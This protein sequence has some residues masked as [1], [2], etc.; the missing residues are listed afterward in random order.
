M[1]R[2]TVLFLS[3]I[4][5]VGA[6]A[7]LPRSSAYENYSD[8]GESGQ[9]AGCHGEF[10][11]A[12]QSLAENTMWDDDLHDV[13]RQR[14]LDAECAACHTGGFFPV[15]VGSSDGVEGVPPYGCSGCH[16][17]AEDGLGTGTVG[18]GAGLRQEHWRADDDHPDQDLKVCAACHDDSDPAGYTPVPESTLPPYYGST[19]LTSTPDDPCNRSPEFG[20]DYAG[21][22]LGLD[23]DGDGLYDEADSDCQAAAETDCFDGVDNDEDGMTDCA[24]PD[25]VEASGGTCDTGEAGICAAGTL[26]CSGGAEQCL[27]DTEPQAEGPAGDATCGDALD[28]DCDGATDEIDPDC[29]LAAETDCFDGTDNDD[30]AL[31]GCADADCDGATGEPCQTDQLGLCEAGTSTCVGGAA[32]CVSDSEPQV[33]GPAGSASCTDQVDND[34]DGFLDDVDPDCQVMAEAECFDG[35]DNDDDGLFDCADPDCEGVANGGCTTDQPG[36]CAVGS[37]VCTSGM[38]VCAPDLQA[39]PEGDAFVNCDDDLD[40]DC[41][42]L[43]DLDDEDCQVLGETDCFDGLDDDDDGLVDCADDDCEGVADGACDTGQPGVCA[44]GSYL[45]MSGAQ[46]CSPD[47]QPQPEGNMY[48]N[49]ADG[50]DNDCDGL[51]DLDDG[52]CDSMAADVWLTKLIAHNKVNLQVGVSKPRRVFVKARA[53]TRP[54]Q[55]TVTLTADFDDQGLSVVLEPQSLTQTVSPED[56]DRMFMF[57]PIVTCNAVGSYSVVWTAE[58]AAAE[59]RQDAGDLLFETTVVKCRPNTGSDQSSPLHEQRRTPRG[60]GRKP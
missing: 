10:R 57:R 53:D 15:L 39:E 4:A 32:Q 40:N 30:D 5:L 1:L 37:Y 35:L 28:N 60:K 54:Q 19:V 49:C 18:F 46:I 17:R 16:G 56:D 6:V 41:D 7:S 26:A 44:A 2:K 8:D 58:I 22:S 52:D 36:I 25:C 38:Q 14:M 9:C 23:N 11:V 34:C 45:C 29:Q 55:A 27:P 42:G 47:A 20:E 33:E 3:A 13:H 51:V 50:L 31:G 48:D 12:R 59:N 21:L 43:V 24:D